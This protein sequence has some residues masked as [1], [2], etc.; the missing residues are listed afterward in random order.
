[1]IATTDTTIRATLLFLAGM[2]LIG[3]LYFTR[4]LLAPFALAIFVWLIIDE[5]TAF[6]LPPYRRNSLPGI[7]NAAA[8]FRAAIPRIGERC[9]GA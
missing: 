6:H 5:Q 9:F 8:Y 1:M 3:L 4:E 2:A 7:T